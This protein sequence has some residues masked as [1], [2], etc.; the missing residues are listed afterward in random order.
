MSEVMKADWHQLAQEIAQYLEP[1]QEVQSVFGTTDWQQELYQSVVDNL[2]GMEQQLAEPIYRFLTGGINVNELARLISQ[3]QAGSSAAWDELESVLQGMDLSGITDVYQRV[4]QDSSMKV[5]DAIRQQARSMASPRKVETVFRF[6]LTNPRA[7]KWA[8]ERAADL[9][10][11]TNYSMRQDLRQLVMEAVSGSMTPMQAARFIGPRVGLAPTQRRTVDRYRRNVEKTRGP[12]VASQMAGKYARRLL[13]YRAR[14]IARTEIMS[15]QNAGQLG[16]WQHKVAIGQLPTQVQKLWIITRDDRL[17]PRCAQMTGEQAL[18]ALDGAWMFPGSRKS[19][20]GVLLY[21]PPG[22]PNC[23]CTHGLF[24]PGF[25][26]DSQTK[27][28][29]VGMDGEDVTPIE[30]LRRE[31][32]EPTWR[33]L[34]AIGG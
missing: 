22:H 6:G 20:G 1:V 33:V 3:L 34:E 11:R 17:C 30:K 21:H 19:Q 5:A 9:V 8:K 32:G 26:T 14:T 18:A 23:R 24:M 13:G 25:L 2:T 29:L 10:V 28:V 27:A 16:L 7:Q 4:Y 12:A 31:L 15:A